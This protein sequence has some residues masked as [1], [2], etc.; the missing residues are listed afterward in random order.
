M[1]L[2]HKQPAGHFGK[3]GQTESD[4]NLICSNPQ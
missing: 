3:H 4:E 1:R 2:M